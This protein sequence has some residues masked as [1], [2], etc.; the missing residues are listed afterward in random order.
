MICTS[1]DELI[2]TAMIKLSIVLLSVLGWAESVEAYGRV[3][4]VCI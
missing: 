2:T 4:C 1:F 3:N